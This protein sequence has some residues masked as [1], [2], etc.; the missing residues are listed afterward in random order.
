[1]QVVIAVAAREQQMIGILDDESVVRA[2][3]ELDK[4]FVAFQRGFVGGLQLAL[5]ETQRERRVKLS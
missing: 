5:R 1:M 2:G 3:D 4:D